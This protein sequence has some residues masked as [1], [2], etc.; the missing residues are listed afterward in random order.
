MPRGA[1][2]QGSTDRAETK[3]PAATTGAATNAAEDR[4]RRGRDVPESRGGR[5][6]RARNGPPAGARG[7]CRDGRGCGLG[8]GR[9]RRAEG[10]NAFSTHPRPRGR[11]SRGA[12]PGTGRGRPR[13]RGRRPPWWRLGA[14]ERRRGA[15]GAPEEG[16]ARLA[17]PGTGGRGAVEPAQTGAG[18]RWS[19]P[20]RP[21]AEERGRRPE[22]ERTADPSHRSGAETA[23]PPPRAD[24]RGA[25]VE[26]KS[27]GAGC[28]GGEKRTARRAFGVTASSDWALRLVG[29][30][31]RGKNTSEE[32]GQSKQGR[33][34]RQKGGRGKRSEATGAGTAVEST[35]PLPMPPLPERSSPTTSPT[36]P[37]LQSPSV[38]E[39]NGERSGRRTPRA[40]R[41]P[42]ASSR[43]E[44]VDDGSAPAAPL[45]L[46]R[47]PPPPAIA[48]DELGSRRPR[49]SSLQRRAEQRPPSGPFS[50]SPFVRRSGRKTAKERG[51]AAQPPPLRLGEREGGFPATPRGSRREGAPLPPTTSPLRSRHD[52]R[53]YPDAVRPSIR[54]PKP[55]PLPLS[56]PRLPRVALPPSR[57]SRGRPRETRPGTGGCCS[58]ARASRCSRR[59]WAWRR[60]RWQSP[61]TW[62]PGTR[63]RPPGWARAR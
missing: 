13:Q 15:A 57:K 6:A 50:H 23:E 17:A 56:V 52:P 3:R 45:S 61:C 47:S 58:T 8:R 20:R 10:P 9:P 42:A 16:G 60:T 36:R 32:S 18:G 54:A 59:R 48:A 63:R 14:A 19:P 37:L 7:G 1:A 11:R 31:S 38:G 27:N 39:P 33:K 34:G 43:G 62:L 49:P 5:A 12:A 40:P 30:T 44:R 55:T 53:P 2:P 29:V 22:T 24:G 26:T 35:A 51:R 21:E 25:D 41:P 28:G 4:A 46:P